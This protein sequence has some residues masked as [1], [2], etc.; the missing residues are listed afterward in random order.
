MTNNHQEIP[1][2]GPEKVRAQHRRY[3][4]TPVSRET[5]ST[6]AETANMEVIT[7]PGNHTYSGLRGNIITL[8]ARYQDHVAGQRGTK[9]EHFD[10]R[11]SL[12]EEQER[13]R[14][15]S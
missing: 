10:K 11:L 3:T 14:G 15:Y 1:T 4:H 8:P 12:S 6:D 7:F 2:T 9:I 5:A 13:K